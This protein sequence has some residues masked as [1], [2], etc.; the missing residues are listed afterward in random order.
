M[1][2]YDKEEMVREQFLKHDLLYVYKEQASRLN[3]RHSFYI[4][5]S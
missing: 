4:L 2:H 3:S 1:F 5:G